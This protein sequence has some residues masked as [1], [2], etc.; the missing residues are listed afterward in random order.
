MNRNGEKFGARRDKKKKAG[1]HY[2]ADLVLQLPARGSGSVALHFV[3]L[4]W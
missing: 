2:A 4:D 3:V 1:G